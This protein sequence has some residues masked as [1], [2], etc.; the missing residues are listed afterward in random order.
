MQHQGAVTGQLQLI[1]EA[2]AVG[3][4][5]QVVQP[6]VRRCS[7]AEVP[8]VDPGLERCGVDT[9]LADAATGQALRRTVAVGA[10]QGG[11]AH[12]QVLVAP[13][14]FAGAGLQRTAE[15]GPLQAPGAAL[16]VF[17]VGSDVPPFDAV[18][19]VRTVI[20]RKAEVPAGRHLGK[21]R[22]GF[23]QPGEAFPRGRLGIAAHQQQ[24]REHRHPHARAHG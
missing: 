18:V 14:R 13:A 1:A 19:R 2:A 16:F 7:A 22:R 17:Q 4:Q 21:A 6:R 24:G 3:L 11:V 23:A 8:V 10:G 12:P 9:G 20:G 15:Q 5:L